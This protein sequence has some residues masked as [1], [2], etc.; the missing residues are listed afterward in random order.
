LKSS[1]K[2]WLFG[3]FE[4]GIWYLSALALPGADGELIGNTF[5]ALADNIE[6]F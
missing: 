6:I 4:K 1:Q 3:E 5:G 2:D